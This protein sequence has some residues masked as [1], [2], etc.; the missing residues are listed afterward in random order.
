M[1]SVMPQPENISEDV[2][3]SEDEDVDDA[4]KKE[5][6]GVFGGCSVM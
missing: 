3:D 4:G 5:S 6:A 2:S 1:I